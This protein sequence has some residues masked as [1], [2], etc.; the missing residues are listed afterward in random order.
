MEDPFL[1]KIFL[2]YSIATHPGKKNNPTDRGK[3]IPTDRGKMILFAPSSPTVF[4]AVLR[5]VV[6]LDQKAGFD[7]AVLVI[8]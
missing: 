8:G 2:S 7:H 1:N 5:V 4:A 6:K 3:M